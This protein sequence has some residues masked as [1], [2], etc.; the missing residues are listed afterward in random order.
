MVSVTTHFDPNQP[1]EGT[2][3]RDWLQA[4]AKEYSDE[5]MRQLG[6]AC[7]LVEYAGEVAG[8]L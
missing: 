4:V 7:D 3:L 2:G 1:V 5:E 8:S 6:M